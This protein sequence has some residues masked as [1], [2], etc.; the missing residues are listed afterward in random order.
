MGDVS[1]SGPF[2]DGRRDQVVQRLQENLKKSVAQKGENLVRQRLQESIR[3][4]RGVYESHIQTEHQQ[5]DLMVTDGGMVYGPWLEGVGSRNFPK[6][7]FKGYASFRLATQEL[8][9]QV[10]SIADKELQIA[11]AELNS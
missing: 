9:R 5:N 2:F 7:R 11:V 10:P 1:T 3:V 8:E 4:N 6:T